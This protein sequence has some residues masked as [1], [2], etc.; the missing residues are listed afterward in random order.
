MKKKFSCTNKM[1]NPFHYYIVMGH[2][3]GLKNMFKFHLRTDLMHG[4]IS[5]NITIRINT[6]TLDYR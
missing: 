3:L 5:A 1:L 6:L 2:K 4:F